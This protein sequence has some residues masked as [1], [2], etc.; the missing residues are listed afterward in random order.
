MKTTVLLVKPL[1]AQICGVFNYH[2]QANCKI[3]VENAVFQFAFASFVEIVRIV[4]YFGDDNGMCVLA[5]DSHF[6]LNACVLLKSKLSYD[7]KSAS[8]KCSR[9]RSVVGCG[10]TQK[11]TNSRKSGP[12][13]SLAVVKVFMQS[14]SIQQ[15][16]LQSNGCST[17]FFEKTLSS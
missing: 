10:Q 15:D 2:Q 3:S 9:C 7:A 17:D 12:K 11:H 5:G 6:L 16:H 1:R 14:V 13:N 4:T 8:I